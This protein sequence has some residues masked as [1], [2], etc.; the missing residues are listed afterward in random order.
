LKQVLA[1]RSFCL[2]NV[3]LLASA[4]WRLQIALIML[5]VAVA[6]VS[7]CKLQ[8]ALGWLCH[9]CSALLLRT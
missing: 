1:W 6:H 8:I 4:L 2:D 9:C 3:T 7:A 5:C